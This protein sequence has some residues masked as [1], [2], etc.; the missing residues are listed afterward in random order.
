MVEAESLFIDLSEHVAYKRDAPEQH[1]LLVESALSPPATSPDAEQ[2]LPCDRCLASPG[3]SLLAISN[4]T[5]FTKPQVWMRLDA[6]MICCFVVGILLRCAADGILTA[7]DGMSNHERSAFARNLTTEIKPYVQDQDDQT[8]AKILLVAE[9]IWTASDDVLISTEDGVA[10]N[11][12]LRSVATIPAPPGRFT[13]RGITVALSYT[14]DSVEL[15]ASEP[16]LLRRLGDQIAV[17]FGVSTASL[18]IAKYTPDIQDAMDLRLGAPF[19]VEV[20]ACI[21]EIIAAVCELITL[22]AEGCG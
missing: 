21:C 1:P 14:H 17:R 15:L 9:E 22:C 5:T 12:R 19:H 16:D 6:L 2:R 3:T 11:L 7:T 8:D 13:K 4:M 20:T 10:F 18:A